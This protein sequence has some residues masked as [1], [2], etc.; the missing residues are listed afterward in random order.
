MKAIHLPTLGPCYWALISLASVFGANLG[1][2][3]SHD[4]HG[5]HWRGLLPLL[6]ILLALL[7]AERRSTRP[8]E[9]FYWLAILTVRA[10]ATN[11]AD[12]ATHDGGVPYLWAV[13]ALA[14]LLALVT[15]L[16]GRTRGASGMPAATGVYWLGMLL[17]GTLGTAIGDGTADELGLGVVAGSAVLGLVAAGLFGLRRVVAS[18]A[19]YWLTVVAVRAAGTT[20]GD[21]C[22][23]TLGLEWSTVLTG[24]LFAAA[25][26]ALPRS[27]PVAG[28]GDPAVPGQLAG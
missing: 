12:L 4:L 11:L 28:Q 23:H 24:L 19:T 22:A 17:A 21:L 26:L 18:A 3:I 1:D 10:A 6:A 13:L 20:L 25:Y 7:T 15:G 8:T 5:G 14:A 9:L 16:V 27:A 2:F